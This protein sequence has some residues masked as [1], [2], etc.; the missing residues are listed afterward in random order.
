M[1]KP[2]SQSYTYSCVLHLQ[3]NIPTNYDQAT[4]ASQTSTVTVVRKDKRMATIATLY[5]NKP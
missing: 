5:G 2:T 1:M 4:Q 3:L